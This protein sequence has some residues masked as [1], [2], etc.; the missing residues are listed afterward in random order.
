MSGGGSPS[1]RCAS[2]HC[3]LHAISE[4]LFLWSMVS[5]DTPVMLGHFLRHYERA[6]LR[7]STHAAFVVHAPRNDTS[8]CA[9]VLR[10]L[11]AHHVRSVE[12]VDSYHSNVKRARVNAHIHTLPA[13]SWLIYADVDE[14]FHFPCQ[15][16][17]ECYSAQ[18][19][20]RLPR[21][22][23]VRAMLSDGDPSEQFPLCAGVRQRLT[24]LTTKFVLFRVRSNGSTPFFMGSHTLRIRPMVSMRC[25]PLGAA[26]H[27]TFT[28]EQLLLARKKSQLYEGL[29]ARGKRSLL[30]RNNALVY[31]KYLALFDGDSFSRAGWRMVTSV[32][33]CCPSTSSATTPEAGGSAASRLLWLT[34]CAPPSCDH[35]LPP[36]ALTR[37][38]QHAAVRVLV[39]G[40]GDGA[41]FELREKLRLYRR[42]VRRAARQVT[43]VI[44]TDALDVLPSPSSAEEILGGFA[45]LGSPLVFSAQPACWAGHWC[46]RGE[47]ERMLA[48]RPELARMRRFVNSG[49]LMGERQAVMHFLEWGVN[50]TEANCRQRDVGMFLRG[51]GRQQVPT[52][53]EDQGLAL[54][55]WQEHT[56]VQLDYANLLFA[57]LKQPYARLGRH[58]GAAVP[59]YD[60]VGGY[61]YTSRAGR[62]DFAWECMEHGVRLVWRNQSSRVMPLVGW[63]ANGGVGRR[64]LADVESLPK[65][66]CPFKH[67]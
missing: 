30:N 39:L 44:C 22:P 36:K 20:D 47:V 50:R 2:R 14:L 62:R 42:A 43:H 21:L 32:Q 52:D 66:K 24:G 4:K 48:N 58:H 60:G 3:T 61:A 64:I 31:K 67:H 27:Y 55:Y 65:P 7:V 12:I 17:H 57:T 28:K 9:A 5:S 41:R 53:C 10:V 56:A 34:V 46:S 38:V 54:A 1:A 25:A 51:G 11:A 15:L 59:L 63:H 40:G 16:D 33:S 23:V 29:L 37:L 45:R 26:D 13:D 35:R 18:L 8:L 19:V 49:Q 6:G